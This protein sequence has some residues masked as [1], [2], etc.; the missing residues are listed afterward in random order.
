MNISLRLNLNIAVAGANINSEYKHPSDQEPSVG[1]PR[2]PHDDTDQAHA[3]TG[4]NHSEKG[5]P[6]ASD[7]PQQTSQIYAQVNKSRGNNA[8]AI[9]GTSQ[10][11]D[12]TGQPPQP[13]RKPKKFSRREEIPDKMEQGSSQTV[14]Y[15]YLDLEKEGQDE[16]KQLVNPQE[17]LYADI[18]V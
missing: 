12:A 9:G 13:L 14:V 8:H 7:P 2:K 17:T 1:I 10:S 18:R 3:A 6:G 11:E 16:N 4:R 15:A 5:R